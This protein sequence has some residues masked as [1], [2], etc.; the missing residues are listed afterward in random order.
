MWFEDNGSAIEFRCKGGV[1]YTYIEQG[2]DAQS[3][4]STIVEVLLCTLQPQ[5]RPGL[6]EYIVA[7]PVKELVG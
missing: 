3:T 6:I 7:M 1:I 5:P 2:S 4:H